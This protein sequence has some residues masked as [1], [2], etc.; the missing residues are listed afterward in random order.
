MEKDKS[1]FVKVDGNYMFAPFN[2]KEEYKEAY[3]SV[4]KKIPSRDRFE[5]LVF[6]ERVRST[7][8]TE[9]ESK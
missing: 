9:R 3:Q 6:V 7:I 8:L 5:F 1:Q 2:S 4:N